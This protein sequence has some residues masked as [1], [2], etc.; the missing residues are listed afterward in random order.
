MNSVLTLFFIDD[1]LA[2]DVGTE[3]I[4]D[5]TV[6]SGAGSKNSKVQA[7]SDRFVDLFKRVARRKGEVEE[8]P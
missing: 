1:S 7:A 3:N 4:V 6:P 5:S 8:K 2:N